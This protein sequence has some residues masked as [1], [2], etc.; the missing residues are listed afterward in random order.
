MAGWWGVLHAGRRTGIDLV[1]L[2]DITHGGGIMLHICRGPGEI[3]MVGL[4]D[5]V[6]GSGEGIICK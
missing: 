4:L 1:V 5:V 6:R 3:Y 2:Q